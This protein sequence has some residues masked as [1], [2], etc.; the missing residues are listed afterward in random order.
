[1]I[2]FLTLT[3]F[4]ILVVTQLQAQLARTYQWHFGFNLALDFSNG[5]PVAISGSQQYTTEG[6][7]TIS[8]LSG[9]LLWYTN[10]GGRDP[11]Q[12]GQSAGAIWNRDHDVMY[13]MSYTEGGGFSSAQS[14]VFV[15]KP[16]APDRYFLFTM[17]EVE[18][19]IGGSVSG[20]PTGRGLSWFE[21]D[22][23][24]NGGL[25]GVV[26]YEQE[27]Y[28]PTYEGVCAI[29]HS[30]GEDWWIIA[31]RSDLLGFVIVPV[32]A[33]GVGTPVEV[34]TTPLFNNVI[35]A[36]P[37]G[38][39]LTTIGQGGRYLFPFDASN[40]TL[41]SPLQLPEG[42]QVEFS[43]NS[44][45][46]FALTKGGTPEIH[47][48]DLQSPDILASETTLGAM[49][50]ETDGLPF[51]PIITYPQLGPDQNIY[52]STFYL[53]SSG[54]TKSYLSAIICANTGGVLAPNHLP[55]GEL[56]GGTSFFIGLPNFPAAWLASETVE[57]LPVDLGQ[58]TILCLGATLTLGQL[59]PGATYSW[60]TG[61][62][63]GLLSITEPGSYA[64]TVSTPCALGVDTIQVIPTS[65]VANAGPDVIICQGE[66]VQIG[67]D[68]IG[69][70]SWTPDQFLDDPTTIS[71]LATPDTTTTY[72]LTV[73]EG[74]CKLTDSMVVNVF[75][76]PEVIWNI[77]D[78]TVGKGTTLLV[79][80][81]GGTVLSWSPAS[82]V[83]CLTCTET[84]VTVVETT[85]LTV[86]LIGL[87][88]C[89]TID[90]VLITVDSEICQPKFPNVFTPNGDQT[91]DV[92]GPVK[93]E[94]PYHLQVW[95]RWGKLIYD[96]KTNGTGW[97]GKVDD[98]DA[99][100]DVYA[101]MMT[102]SVCGEIKSIRGEVTLV[103]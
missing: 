7:A 32:T 10:G 87:N 1:M 63:T 3:I 61:D 22:A 31:D 71:P 46:L 57:D 79:N 100:S 80:V 41:L 16:G 14:S 19:N 96:N 28:G 56:S 15:T 20:Q 4:Y 24:L 36:S 60:S 91:N 17:E 13:D 6:C 33:A 72:L 103:R 90:S 55:M 59:F 84:T 30:N 50:A 88:G 9:H 58:D 89:T 82:I 49:P 69:S 27:I 68:A 81:Q 38:K 64:V 83:N 85:Y 97:D 35:K 8:D 37:D 101:W 12:S 102:A 47:R 67:Q 21:I 77:Q 76:A 70:I 92:F 51:L 5:S 62:T 93:W 99:P 39:W 86:E 53:T 73:T 74:G 98:T 78:T 11:I 75:P 54:G 95:S 43:A 65:L 44:R 66:S 48:F 34:T 52:F 45:W 26:A 42:S 18:Y 25:G 94:Q 29:Q 23:T 2:R 40:G